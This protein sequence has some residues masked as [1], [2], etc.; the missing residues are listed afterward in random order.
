MWQIGQMKSSNNEHPNQSLLPNIYSIATFDFEGRTNANVLMIQA[1]PLF[2]FEKTVSVL[3]ERVPIDSLTLLVNS[4]SKLSLENATSK[5]LTY[6]EQLTH[7]NEKLL[8]KINEHQFSAIYVVTPDALVFTLGFDI[9]TT[10]NVIASYLNIFHFVRSLSIDAENI[11]F[12]SRNGTVVKFRDFFGLQYLTLGGD[13]ITIMPGTSDEESTLLYET[14]MDAYGVGHCLEIGTHAGGTS[15]ILGLASRQ[16]GGKPV[17]TIDLIHMEIADHF[18]SANGLTNNVNRI[19]GDSSVIGNVWSTYVKDPGIGLLFID[20]DHSYAGVM[21]DIIHW[22]PYLLKGGYIV[23]HDL[24][25]FTGVD[26]AFYNH[27]YKNP[28]YGEFRQV[29]SMG[30]A[31]KIA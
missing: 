20:G 26:E 23:I 28:Q 30:V 24:N 12:I 3:K 18:Y 17:H 31:K 22:T 19:T 10:K 1:C 11:G 5:I 14:A 9:I 4:N 15:C 25:R 27:I 6:G 7:E 29:D 2:Q 21:S 13:E 16:S 8:N